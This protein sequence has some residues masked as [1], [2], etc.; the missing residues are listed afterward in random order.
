MLSRIEESNITDSRFKKAN[1]CLLLA[2]VYE[3]V[4]FKSGECRI[5]INV[6]FSIETSSI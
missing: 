2:R 1:I 3:K 6:S 5:Y 4:V